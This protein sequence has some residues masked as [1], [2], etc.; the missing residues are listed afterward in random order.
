[1][2]AAL[3]ADDLP[4]VQAISHRLKGD[5]DNLRITALAHAAKEINYIAKTSNDKLLIY[6]Y[7]AKFKAAHRDLCAELKRRELLPAD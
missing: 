4:A 3:P 7:L 6:E 5:Y 2:E 1:M